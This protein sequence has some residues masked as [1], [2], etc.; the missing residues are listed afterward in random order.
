MC[1]IDSIEI[2]GLTPEA[3]GNDEPSATITFGVSHN[4]PCGLVAEVFGEPPIR[5][6][7]M[8]WNEARGHW[9]AP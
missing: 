1:A 4:A 3:D 8:M 7:P 2:I 6:E 9:P 5:A